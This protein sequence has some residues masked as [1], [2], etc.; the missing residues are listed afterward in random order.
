MMLEADDTAIT[1]SLG[2]IRS[3]S[4]HLLAVLDDLRSVVE[5]ELI[6]ERAL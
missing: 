4:Q 1:E 6:Q 2:D 3:T 5:P